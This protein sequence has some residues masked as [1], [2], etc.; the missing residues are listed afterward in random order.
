MLAWLTRLSRQPAKNRVEGPGPAPS[1]VLGHTQRRKVWSVPCER[2][3]NGQDVTMYRSTSL[4]LRFGGASPTSPTALFPCDASSTSSAIAEMAWRLKT[5]SSILD[6]G[7]HDLDSRLG[8]IFLCRGMI[9]VTRPDTLRYLAVARGAVSPCCALALAR[10]LLSV[11]RAALVSFPC[12]TD[13]KT[14]L[15]RPQDQDV[16]LSGLGACALCICDCS[17]SLYTI[18]MISMCMVHI[19]NDTPSPPLELRAMHAR[20]L[21]S[22]CRLLAIVSQTS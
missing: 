12:S 10:N 19:Q 22:C 16:L 21:Q 3:E 7:G 11:Q 14:N 13:F 5:A 18:L 2:S 4:V 15:Y 6:E 17:R 9:V 20:L 1:V 8:S